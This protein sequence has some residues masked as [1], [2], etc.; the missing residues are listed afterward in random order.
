MTLR[1]FMDRE[2][3]T[4]TQLAARLGCKVNTVHQWVSGA[5]FP[6]ASAWPR[7]QAVTAGRVTAGDMAKV[8]AVHAA[9][10]AA[11]PLSVSLN[12]RVKDHPNAG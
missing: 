11:A 7:I 2:S 3:L 8:R 5:R 4:V 9:E 1:E 6:T 10:P 12:E